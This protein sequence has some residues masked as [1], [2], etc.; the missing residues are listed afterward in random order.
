M[1]Q[2]YI[3]GATYRDIGERLAMS[4]TNVDKV[5]RREMAKAA[6][7][8]DLLADQALATFVERTEAIFKA[9]FPN[10]LRGDYKASVICDRIL[11]RQARLYGLTD[12][13]GAATV[14]G[15]DDEDTDPTLLGGGEDKEDVTR[16]DEWRRR[17]STG[18]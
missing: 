17:S 11:A 18:T 9:H 3:A 13:G 16:L 5:I 2:M 12:G 1:L 10:A 14:M 8:R 7:R 15:P 6:K 4:H